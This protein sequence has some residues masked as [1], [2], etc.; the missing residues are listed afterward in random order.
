MIILALGSAGAITAAVEAF[1]AWLNRDRSRHVVLSWADG[2]D[3]HRIELVGD[4]LSE[5]SVRAAYSPRWSSVKQ[6]GMGE[7][8]SVSAA[9][10]PAGWQY[11]LFVTYAEADRVG[12]RLPRACARPTAG[13]PANPEDFRPGAPVVVEF[14]RAIAESRFTAVILSSAYLADDWAVFEEQL[15]SHAGRGAP[16][17]RDPGAPV[18][19]AGPATSRVPCSHR[20]HRRAPLGTAG[21]A[22]TGPARAIRASMRPYRAHT[23]GWCR[24][25]ATMPA[26]SMGAKQRSRTWCGG[27]A[28]STS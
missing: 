18:S 26:S 9:R 15:A 5:D 14:G 20:L 25:K 24:S 17:H 6:S 4:R 28:T 21:G 2:D 8:A 3:E 13:A 12:A 11:D 22:S 1:K 27:F 19:R 16:R 10:E 23:R 7:V